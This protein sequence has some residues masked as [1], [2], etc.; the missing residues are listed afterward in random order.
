V[1]NHE[2]GRRAGTWADRTGVINP[3]SFPISGIALDNSD[4][5]GQTAFVTIMG[6]HVSHVWKTSN[7][8]QSWTDF[9]LGLPDSPANAVV[10]DSN[11]VPSTVYVGS[12]EGVFSTSTASPSWIEV[13]PTPNQPGF[14]PNVS[15]TALRLFNSGG[16]KRLRASTYGRGIW[17]FWSDFQ[18]AFSNNP[19]TVFVGQTAVFAG[20]LTGSNGYTSS[21]VSRFE[22]YG[23]DG[24]GL[25]RFTQQNDA[26]DQWGFNH[27]DCHWS[28]GRLRTQRSWNRSQ[29]SRP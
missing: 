16:I 12:D 21:V 8:G 25:Y 24:T 14:L 23:S 20:T 11:S 29:W 26:D 15:V 28:R 9:S 17:E 22:L 18:A 13:A 2:C 7:A 19:L 3:G 1:G 6:F 27:G 10:V 5:S 4:A